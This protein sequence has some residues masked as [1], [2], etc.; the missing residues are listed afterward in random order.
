LLAIR[1]TV[2]R[3]RL[4]VKFIDHPAQRNALWK[5][6]PVAVLGRINKYQAV[7]CRELPDCREPLIILKTARLKTAR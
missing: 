2:I 5:N 1:F 4:L 6:F 3:R 7:P